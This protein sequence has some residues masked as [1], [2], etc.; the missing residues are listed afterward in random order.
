LERKVQGIADTKGASVDAQLSELKNTLLQSVKV[1]QSR[2]GQEHGRISRLESFLEKLR[3]DSNQHVNPPQASTAQLEDKV[4][5]LKEKL[6]DDTKF[7]VLEE[8]LNALYAKADELSIRFANL[9]F[10]GQPE[11]NAWLAMNIPSHNFGWIVDPHI[12]MEH[13][14]YAIS[15]EDTL[16]RLESIY[17]LK[18]HTI[19]QGLAVSS[20]EHKVPKFFTQTSSYRV[21]KDDSSYSDAIP[22]YADWDEKDNGWR[23]KLEE[24]LVS[25]QTSMEDGIALQFGPGTPSYHLA[26]LSVTR[27][28]GWIRGLKDF[29]D[30]YY[31]ELTR[32]KFGSKKAWHVTTRLAKRL[33]VEVAAPRVGVVRAL[34]AGDLTQIARTIF[35]ASLRSLDIMERIQKNQFKIIHS[36][37]LSSSNSW[38]STRVSRPSSPSPNRSPKT[39]NPSKTQPSCWSQPTKLP[40]LRR[41]KPTKASDCSKPR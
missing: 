17:K 15:A 26:S 30:E 37:P 41:T 3:P 23:D 29:I 24:E 18:L 22:T 21:I 10:R 16:K 8:K 40:T 36:S 27:S 7:K 6:H 13:V 5:Q 31:K 28:V 35:W 25:F 19:A 32:G 12:L 2:L 34:H 9:G 39:K 14:H 38:P 4:R 20:F 33:L 11:A 1:I